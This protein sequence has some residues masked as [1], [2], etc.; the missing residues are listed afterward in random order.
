M[1]SRGG[2]LPGGPKGR[3]SLLRYGLLIL[4]WSVVSHRHLC[5]AGFLLFTWGE[6]GRGKGLFPYCFHLEAVLGCRR[7]QISLPANEKGKGKH[8]N[9]VRVFKTFPTHFKTGIHK[10]VFLAFK[11]IIKLQEVTSLIAELLQED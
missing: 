3:H 5:P 11:N 6:R 9:F 10:D 7:Y 8:A 2:S 4:L 1:V